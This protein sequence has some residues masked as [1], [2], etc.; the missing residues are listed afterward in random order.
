MFPNSVTLGGPGLYQIEIRVPRDDASTWSLI[1]QTYAPGA[2]VSAPQQEFLPTF[3]ARI[4]DVPDYIAGQDMAVWA[5]QGVVM[6]RTLERLG[7]T[8]RGLIMYRK[9]LEEQ[10]QVV[11]DGGDPLNTFRDPASN[12]VLGREHGPVELYHPGA[13]RLRTSGPYSP[14]MDDLDRIMVEAAAASR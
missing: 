8:D 13:V 9:M 1:Y 12:A 10:M 11:Q 4:T 5:D 6:D 14:I 3:E 7:D 2:G